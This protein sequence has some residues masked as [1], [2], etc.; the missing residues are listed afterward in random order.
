M[1]I[2]LFTFSVGKTTMINNQSIAEDALKAGS[3]LGSKRDLRNQIQ[4]ILPCSQLL[5]Y[6]MNI[7]IRLPAG[8]DTM[9]QYNIFTR[10]PK[11]LDFID[12]FIL[13]L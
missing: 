1:T 3:K 8:G 11:S 5:F 12:T 7:D 2:S 10:R 13:Y 9:K 6:Q 4:Y